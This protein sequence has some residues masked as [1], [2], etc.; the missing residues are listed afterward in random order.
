MSPLLPW[1]MRLALLS[2]YCALVAYGL[3]W[4]GVPLLVLFA[5]GWGCKAPAVPKP[6][7]QRMTP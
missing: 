3:G 2:W 6:A 7:A 1:A 4:W 5:T